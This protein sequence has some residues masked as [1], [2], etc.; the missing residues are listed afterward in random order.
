MLY[1]WSYKR[2]WTRNMKSRKREQDN[3]ASYRFITV[4]HN[5]ALFL[6]KR[7]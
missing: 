7:Y 5:Q 2:N 4:Y 6:S 1:R 3:S